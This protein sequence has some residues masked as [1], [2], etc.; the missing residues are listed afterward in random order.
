MSA[1]VKPG[2][3]VLATKW[4]DGD[5]GDQFAVGFYRSSYDHFGSVR[6][7]VVDGAGQQFRANGFRRVKR[8]SAAR[9]AWLI[10][11]FPEIEKGSRSLWWWC[12][13]KMAPKPEPPEKG[14][15]G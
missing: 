9:G 10:A 13:Q 1:D 14:G 4:R 7:S 3:Y 12:R 6:H 2:D 11:H 15:A 8:I 5:P